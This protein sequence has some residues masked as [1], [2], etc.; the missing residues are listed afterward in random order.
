[1]ADIGPFF[2]LLEE[3]IRNG[4]IPAIIGRNVSDMEREIIS[5]PYRFGI[6]GIQILTETAGP[7][8]RASKEITNGLTDLI[9]N[10]DD[11]VENF[12]KVQSKQARNKLKTDKE[13]MLKTKV[14][15]LKEQLSDTQKRAIEAAE[16]NGASSWLTVLTIQS[17]G[18]H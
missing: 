8:Y 7:E 14:D 13:K 12:N 6:L 9:F 17:L 16:E 4:L 1:M 11:G 3:T 18:M 2:E 10:Q 5:L 15:L